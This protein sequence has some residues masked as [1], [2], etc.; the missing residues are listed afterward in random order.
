MKNYRFYI[1]LL[2]CSLFAHADTKTPLQFL[3]AMVSA[4]QTRNYEQLYLMQKGENVTSLRYRH[5]YTGGREYAQLLHLDELREE[6]ILR[7]GK[8]SYF[9]DF[10]PF[11]L[12][13]PHILDNLPMVM[14]GRFAELKG[15][16]FIDAGRSRIADRPA[17]M[18]RIVPRDDFRYQYML[19]I[20]TETHLLLRSDLLDRDNTVLEQFRVLQSTLDD[21]LLGIVEPIEALRL[22]TFIETKR[23]QTQRLKW[24][25]QWVPEGF[26]RVA[27]TKQRLPEMQMADEV[28]SQLYSD[29]LF[30]FT[31]YVM[32][33]Q[34]VAF[35]EQFWREG[36]TSIYSQSLGGYDVAIIGEIPLVAARHI[37]QDL[38]S[39]LETKTK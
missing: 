21:E 22:P 23:H 4:H 16:H 27:Q 38:R 37:A 29:G 1:L 2:F 31:V 7:D 15:Y 24:Q 10:Q 5:A 32:K 36:K 6:L 17:R 35:D 11:S 20:D 14:Y 26:K 19:W 3:Q 39:R 8:V 9:G 33:N 34:G 12:R 25:P 18:I 28:E 30:S 13:S